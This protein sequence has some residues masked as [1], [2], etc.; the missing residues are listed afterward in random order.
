MYVS[1]VDVLHIYKYTCTPA[2]IHAYYFTTSKPQWWQWWLRLI[3]FSA[4]SFRCL[5][6]VTICQNTF[7]L[8]PPAACPPTCMQALV[9]PAFVLSFFVPGA[10]MQ[11]YILA[12]TITILSYLERKKKIKWNCKKPTWRLLPQ[13]YQSRDSSIVV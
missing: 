1:V 8:T 4:L 13:K 12:K 10:H 3:V 9:C 5:C 7:P 6:F 11:K 2:Y